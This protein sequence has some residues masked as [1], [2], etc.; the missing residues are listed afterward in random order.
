MREEQNEELIEDEWEE[1]NSVIDVQPYEVEPFDESKIEVRGKYPIDSKASLTVDTYDVP[2]FCNTC[3]LADRCPRFKENST[4]YY[5]IK[6]NINDPSDLV[7]IITK[8]IEVQTE[9]VMFGRFIEQMEGGYIDKTL[10]DEIKGLMTL[11]K[12]FKDISDNRDE[13][14]VKIKSRNGEGVLSQIF[15]GKKDTKGE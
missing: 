14:N 10:S 4:C 2:Q 3:Y 13:I 9:R 15:G 12:D 1:D 7:T 8:L 5:R 11:M 6:A